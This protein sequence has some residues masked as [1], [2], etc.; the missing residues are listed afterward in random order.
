M[1]RMWMVN[2]KLLCRQHL[3]GEHKELHQLLG[4]LKAGKSILG[5]I[6]DKQVDPISIKERH[7]EIKFEMMRRG[8]NH[9]SDLSFEEKNIIKDARSVDIDSKSNLKELK[10]R[11]ED[12]KKRIKEV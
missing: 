10:E 3:L 6:K 8:Y 1:T 7:Q 5:H 2:P 11:C 4:S 9:N 12:C